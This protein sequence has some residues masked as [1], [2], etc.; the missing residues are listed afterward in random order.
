MYNEFPSHVVCAFRNGGGASVSANKVYGIANSSSCFSSYM[1]TQSI[2]D[3][4]VLKGPLPA[5]SDFSSVF[6]IVYI[7]F[8]LSHKWPDAQQY[9]ISVQS[10]PHLHN[11]L[12]EDPS[13]F[14]SLPRV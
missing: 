9:F 1:L 4:V 12:P 14:L 10:S 5:S 3:Y 6:P 11:Q 8:L 13:Y 7:E 2:A